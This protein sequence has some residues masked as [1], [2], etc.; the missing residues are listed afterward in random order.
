MSSCVLKRVRRLAGVHSMWLNRFR[1][2]VLVASSAKNPPML[3][4][5]SP[6]CS[7]R[8]PSPCLLCRGGWL[9][10]LAKKASKE[11]PYC[12]ANLEAWASRISWSYRVMNFLAFQ[13]SS[14]QRVVMSRRSL[15]SASWPEPVVTGSAPSYTSSCAR[16]RA[17]RLL[18]VHSM[19][20]NRAVIS[21]FTWSSSKRAL[22]TTM[23]PVSAS[24]LP[25][26]PPSSSIGS[27]FFNLAKNSSKDDPYWAAN[28]A[29][30]AFIT[31][32]SKVANMSSVSVFSREKRLMISV[33]TTSSN[34]TPEAADVA[35]APV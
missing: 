24:F 30:C 8:A 14:S 9:L 2:L 16:K 6:H 31:S 19:S 33:R 35:E 34:N 18:G 23:A 5:T 15:S 20:V 32:L 17:R 10:S 13:P 26:S 12:L 28:L 4:S 29:S 25:P 3:G 21:A 7:W 1:R 27:L 11:S 22:D